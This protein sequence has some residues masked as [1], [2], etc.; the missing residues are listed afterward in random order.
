M[1]EMFDEVLL[2][3]D[4]TLQKNELTKAD[5]KRSES[6][7][8]FKKEHCH[9]SKYSFQVRKCLLESC[10]YCSSHPI[11]LSCEQYKSISF[12]PLPLLDESK[13]ITSH[14]HNSMVVCRMKRTGPLKNRQNVLKVKSW[15][16]QIEGYF[17]RMERCKL[18]Y[19][20]VIALNHVVYFP[21]HH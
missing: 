3:V 14:S 2:N 13:I 18:Y 15:I 9:I 4:S 8:R 7:K 21:T 5:L 19:L 17:L 6:L 11:K 20:V 12:L 16:K 10:Q 1:D